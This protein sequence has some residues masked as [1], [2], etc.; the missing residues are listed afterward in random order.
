MSRKFIGGVPTPVTDAEPVPKSYVDALA[1]GSS[2]KVAVNANV[3]LA[4]PGASLDG[5][6]MSAGDHFLA[7][8]QTTGNQ[9][10]EYVWNGAAST[11][12]R[13][14]TADTSTEMG[15]GSLWTVQQGSFGDQL[16]MLTNDAFVLGTDT[17]TWSF[18]RRPAPLTG[19]PLFRWRRD[20]SKRKMRSINVGL[21]GDSIPFGQGATVGTIPDGT[22]YLDTMT[23]QLQRYLNQLPTYGQ[24]NW[25]DDA[26][27][28]ATTFPRSTGGGYSVRAAYCQLGGFAD[29]WKLVSGTVGY[30]TRGTGQQS[31]QLNAGSRIS[32]TAEDCDGF[33][34]WYENGASQI[35][36][37]AATVYAGDYSAAPTAYYANAAGAP[38]NTGL[39]QYARSYVA[40]Q[41]PRGKWTIEFTPASGTP[42]LDMLYVSSGDQAH[43]V[44]VWNIAWG[45]TGS[46]DWSANTT[47][48]NTAASSAPKLEGFETNRGMDLIVYYIG[49][50]D[51]SGGVTGATFQANLE[52]AIDKYRAAQTRAPVFLLVS[53]FARFDVAT[54]AFPWSTYKAAMRAVTKTRADVDYLDLEPWFPVSQ[55]ADIDDDLVDSSG[56]HLTSAGQ[57]IAAQAIADKLR[58]TLG[59]AA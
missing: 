34:F 25:I 19:D 49:A 35:G 28:T 38:V 52:A 11:A 16:V 8:T 4:S 40:W 37:L 48:A 23:V 39:A 9:G 51:Y 27:A 17:P 7:L 14:L 53:H 5:I 12:T 13:A 54:P 41:L 32:L 31:L 57:A 47:A 55:V 36:A 42:V 26:L 2:V 29:P 44:K 50:G 43:G 1:H 18:F 45:G 56:V 58:F 24:K 21:L 33:L 30:V 15:P 3:N 22:N 20:Y 46:T 10:G 6:T 59:V